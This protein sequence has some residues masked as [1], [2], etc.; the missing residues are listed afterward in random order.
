MR[1]VITCTGTRWGGKEDVRHATPNTHYAIL[2]GRVDP[3]DDLNE[4]PNESYDGVIV[5]IEPFNAEFGPDLRISLVGTP[6]DVAAQIPSSY[7]ENQLVSLIGLCLRLIE[8]GSVRE[9]DDVHGVNE[10]SLW[11]RSQYPGLDMGALRDTMRQTIAINQVQIP[12]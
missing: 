10:I 8:G 5:P 12:D 7:T 6:G 9:V 1:I 4:R 3:I 2:N 11:S